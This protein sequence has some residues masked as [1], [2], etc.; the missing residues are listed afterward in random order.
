LSVIPEVVKALETYDVTT[1]RASV[2]M[3]LVAKYISENTTDTVIFSGEGSDELFCGYLY[4]H[5]A[6]TPED[7]SEESKRLIRELHNYDVL[8]ADRTVSV[9]G[10][11]LRVPFLHTEVL[12]FSL[13]L[14]AEYKAPREGWEKLLL[15]KAF[16]GYLPKDV[17]WRRKNGFS[18]SCSSIEKPWYK[19]IEK[20]VDT[21][22][23][24]ELY[25]DTKYISK[26]AMYYR[27]LF[28]KLFPEYKLDIPMWLPRWSGNVTNPSGMLMKVFDDK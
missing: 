8:R 16:E 24:D 23:G 6:P 17:A 13:G 28:N 12:H 5:N 25:D 22:L 26:E 21:R 15:R 9:H 4:F 27:L 19:Y 7:A 20:H 1:I 10:L 2:P 11:E 18:D 14:P 3:Y